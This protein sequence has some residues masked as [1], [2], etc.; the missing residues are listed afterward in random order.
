[1]NLIVLKDIVVL[2]MRGSQI[3]YDFNHVHY[4]FGVVPK[5]AT[6][7]SRQIYDL[8]KKV[9]TS[10]DIVGPDLPNFW[11]YI[12]NADQEF[13]TQHLY[14]SLVVFYE[15]YVWE[16]SYVSHESE[17]QGEVEYTQVRDKDGTIVSV[18]TTKTPEQIIELDQLI[19]L[20]ED[21]CIGRK[22][23][24]FHTMESVLGVLVDLEIQPGEVSLR[25]L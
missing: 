25:D 17:Y 20:S 14:N 11:T 19:R 23:F 9:N 6:T 16:R 5:F 2:K 8:T 15:L 18:P 10:V 12:K 22:M 7:Y 1:M 21:E 4:N 24:P 3:D 13:V